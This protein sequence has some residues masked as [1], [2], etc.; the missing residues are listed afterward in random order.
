MFIIFYNLHY[1]YTMQDYTDVFYNI[2]LSIYITYNALC[3]IN[4]SHYNT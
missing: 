4:I 3:I 2:I 1:V